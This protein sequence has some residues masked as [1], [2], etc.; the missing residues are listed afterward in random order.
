MRIQIHSQVTKTIKTKC[1]T[2]IAT[3]TTEQ[4][5]NRANIKSN[6]IHIHNNIHIIHNNN[7]LNNNNSNELTIK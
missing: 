4:A 1:L 2:K 3:I 6:N 7:S 5:I